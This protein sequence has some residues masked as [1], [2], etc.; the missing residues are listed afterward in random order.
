MLDHLIRC[1]L[2]VAHFTLRHN[3][4]RSLLMIDIYTMKSTLLVN[5]IVSGKKLKVYK[6]LKH[7]LIIFPGKIQFVRLCNPTVA[8]GLKAAGNSKVSRYVPSN[9]INVECCFSWSLKLTL[10][11][12]LKSFTFI[13]QKL[14]KKRFVTYIVIWYTQGQQQ[15]KDMN[16][17]CNWHGF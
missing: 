2:T 16:S 6:Q 5:E 11:L 10:I 7:L 8:F 4:G 17:T 3:I 14:K 9:Q 12:L 1:R 15:I 13:L